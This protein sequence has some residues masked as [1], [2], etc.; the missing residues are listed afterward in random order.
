MD[1]NRKFI[2]A[3]NQEELSNRIKNVAYESLTMIFDINEM[4]N[5]SDKNTF[6]DCEELIKRISSRIKQ[7]DKRIYSQL[8]FDS[9][10]TYEECK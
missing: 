4:I 1:K 2:K 8:L 6:A 10:S 7:G 9:D 5:K 3:L